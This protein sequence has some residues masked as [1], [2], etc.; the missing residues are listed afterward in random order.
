M[1]FAVGLALVGAIWLFRS[2]VF[3][4]TNFVQKCPLGLV[5]L[6]WYAQDL[7]SPEADL[8][9]QAAL[10]IARRAGLVDV[11]WLL[12]PALADPERGVRRFALYGLSTSRRKYGTLAVSDGELVDKL[13]HLALHDPDGEVRRSAVNVLLEMHRSGMQPALSARIS[14]VVASYKSGPGPAEGPTAEQG[15][16]GS[17]ESLTKR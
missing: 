13:G 7:S 3:R 12:L 11:S 10:A 8:R 6:Q 15:K 5:P 1:V 17:S 14:K 9:V 2:P 4:Y 16:P